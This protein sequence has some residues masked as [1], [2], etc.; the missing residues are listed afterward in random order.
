MVADSVPWIACREPEQ[1][2]EQHV[3]DWQQLQGDCCGEGHGAAL[4][5]PHHE[6]Q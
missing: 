3:Q 4:Q 2:W 5:P 1:R 6:L